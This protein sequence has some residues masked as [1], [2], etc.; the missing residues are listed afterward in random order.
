MEIEITPELKAAIDKSIQRNE[1][2][3]KDA[4]FIYAWVQEVE[5]MMAMLDAVKT[6]MLEIH[7]VKDGYPTFIKAGHNHV[8]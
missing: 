2:N 8:E 3:G 7:G 6:G 5:L 1:I 4:A